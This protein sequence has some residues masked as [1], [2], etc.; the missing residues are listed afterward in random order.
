MYLF[1]YS[2]MALTMVVIVGIVWAL[3]STK[4]N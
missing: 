3:V 2:W 4:G 1:I